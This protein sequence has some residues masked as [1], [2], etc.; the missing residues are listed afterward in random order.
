MAENRKIGFLLE[1]R[2]NDQEIIYYANRFSE[3]GYEARFL[4]R[5]WGQ[6]KVTYKG[7]ELG[8][9][10][11]VD[12]SFENISDYELGNFAAII[13]PS[14]YVADLLRYT[15]K[16]GEIS[17]AVQFIKRIMDKPTMLKGFIGHSLWIF[18]PIP[19]VIRG[20]QVTCHNNII[21]SVKNTGAVYI[22]QDIV[23]DE[24]L[25]TARN[26]ALFAGFARTVIDT[27]H[28]KNHRV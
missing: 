24:D 14:G 12:Q 9:P 1:N 2:F 21:G 27:L 11:T 6:P 3:E 22:D 8:M 25:I 19:E 13:I 23:V 5:L 16:P 28:A 15:E 4:T 20:R 18:D 26:G 10:L 17:P 7:L